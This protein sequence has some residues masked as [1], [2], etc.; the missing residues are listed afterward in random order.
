MTIL[1]VDDDEALRRAVGRVLQTGGFGS[2]AVGSV[3]DAMAAVADYGPD[4]VLLDVALGAESGLD[5]HRALRQS[6]ARLPAVIFTTSRRDVFPTMQEQ[7]G[8]LDDWI[9]KP[10][11]NAE[12][13]ARVRLAARR[14]ATDRVAT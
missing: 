3:A 2:R 13:I 14:V 11:D 8:P 4:I 10:W 9:I 6:H 12:F 7:M 1:I 5:I